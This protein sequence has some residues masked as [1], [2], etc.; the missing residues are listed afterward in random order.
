MV[1]TFDYKSTALGYAFKMAKKVRLV[2]FIR[3]S[4]NEKR[5]RMDLLDACTQPF[6]G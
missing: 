1:R 6:K 5:V 2:E 3:A 4:N